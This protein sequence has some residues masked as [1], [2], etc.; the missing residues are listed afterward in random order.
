MFHPASVSKYECSAAEPLVLQLPFSY[1][2]E[3][4]S[5]LSLLV[6]CV[7]LSYTFHFLI[8]NCW[9]FIIGD[10][11]AVVIHLL[12]DLIGLISLPS[13]VLFAKTELIFDSWLSVK[14][15]NLALL[16]L[17]KNAMM[18]HKLFKIVYELLIIKLITLI[19]YA[20]CNFKNFQRITQK[21]SNIAMV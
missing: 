13:A 12:V 6:Y 15:D 9:F 20:M 3:S 16:F 2:R 11:Y 1:C 17:M 5:E 18:S 8:T 10:G 19:L 7:F 4:V 21:F 14:H